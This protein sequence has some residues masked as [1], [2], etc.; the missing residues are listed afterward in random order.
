MKMGVLSGVKI[1]ICYNV[2]S[3]GFQIENCFDKLV[4]YDFKVYFNEDES[5]ERVVILPEKHLRIILHLI[6]WEKYGNESVKWF[7]QFDQY[8]MESYES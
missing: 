2:T 8:Q 3:V 1:L 4:N 7:V 5:L 6:F